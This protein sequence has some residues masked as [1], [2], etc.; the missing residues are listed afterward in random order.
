MKF[1]VRLAL[2]IAVIFGILWLLNQTIQDKRSAAARPAASPTPAPSPTPLPAGITPGVIMTPYIPASTS[3]A[4]AIAQQVGVQ[5]VGIQD[6][7]GWTL[8][9]VQADDRNK[10]SDF[11]DKLQRSGMRD[12]DPDYQQY[13][14]FATRDGRQVFQN[15]YRVR[16]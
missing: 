5:L 4:R 2:M 15:T 13:R 7:S 12:L 1:F 8:I 11:L 14:Q 16:F 9:T 10:L 6:A 3:H